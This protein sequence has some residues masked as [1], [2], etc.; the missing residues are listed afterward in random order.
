MFLTYLETD[1]TRGG[2][3]GQGRGHCNAEGDV[4]KSYGGSKKG[5]SEG[6]TPPPLPLV[7]V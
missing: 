1:G 3:Q 2:D 7:R 6:T 5:C 4:K